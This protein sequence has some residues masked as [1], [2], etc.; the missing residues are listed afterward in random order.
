[1]GTRLSMRDRIDGNVSTVDVVTPCLVKRLQINEI[2]S[3]TP[4]VYLIPK[5]QRT[6]NSPHSIITEDHRFVLISCANLSSN[7]LLNVV[8]HSTR[9]NPKPFIRY[10]NISTQDQQMHLCQRKLPGRTST[11]T[12][13]M[14]K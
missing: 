8:T 6:Q 2:T 10:S 12:L 9:P 14:S 5:H 7:G 11:S 1:M 3:T 13:K 4:T